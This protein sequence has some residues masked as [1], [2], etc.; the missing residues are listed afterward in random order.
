MNKKILLVAA[1]ALAVSM[2]QAQQEVGSEA[3]EMQAQAQ[4]QVTDVKEQAKTIVSKAQ[5][6][7]V[8]MDQEATMKAMGRQFK[9]LNRAKDTESMKKPLAEFKKYALQSEALGLEA[10]EDKVPQDEDV[11][12][13][14]KNMQ[15]INEMVLDLE[16]AV[17]AGHFDEAK[18]VLKAIRDVQVKGHEYFKID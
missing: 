1:T 11:A 15:D 5:V 18:T 17:E 2:A 16:K 10:D 6:F 8:S 12:T 4:A 3:A 14:Q 7:D 13:F 9:A